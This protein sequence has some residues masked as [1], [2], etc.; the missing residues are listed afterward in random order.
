[1]DT[2]FISNLNWLAVL[3]AAVAYFMLGALWYSKLLF[4]NM[5]IKGTG[6]DM[7]KPDAKKG[8]G[9]IMV[10]TFVLEFII[11]I[12]LAL[13]IYRLVLNGWMSG[14]KL[15]LLT[16]ICFSA[17]TICISYLYQMKPKSL[18][19]IDGGY[20]I[21]GQAIAGIILCIM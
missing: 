7:S 13:L 5:W 15:G 4:G 1:M 12:A 20:H 14:L 6:I 3:V 9:G 18:S 8:V 10:F 21:A 2:T 11:C 19:M 16:G 17:T